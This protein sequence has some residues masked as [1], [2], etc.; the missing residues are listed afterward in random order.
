MKITITEE[1]VKKMIKGLHNN[2]KEV[3]GKLIRIYDFPT[4]KETIDFVN[5]VAEISIEQNHHPEMVIGR[6]TVKVIMFDHEK[7][8]ISKRCYK[9]TDAIDNMMDKE[10]PIDEKSRSFAF[11]RKKT[12]FPKSAMKANPDRFKEYD[13]EVNKIKK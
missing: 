9:F 2:W 13:K 8:E 6:D 1:Q 10:E 12:L 4:Y 3:D 7:G 5:K 11:T